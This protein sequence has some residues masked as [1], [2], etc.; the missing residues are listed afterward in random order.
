MINWLSDLLFD[1]KKLRRPYKPTVTSYDDYIFGDWSEWYEDYDGVLGR[2]RV[3]VHPCGYEWIEWES[4]E[5][6]EDRKFKP[7]FKDPRKK[8][9]CCKGKKDE[10]EL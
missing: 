9:C 8:H 10:L 3:G 4:K 5:A 1:N 2:K 7:T 6:F